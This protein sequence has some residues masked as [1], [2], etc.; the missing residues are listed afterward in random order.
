MSH[1]TYQQEAT[2]AL[3][4]AAINGAAA[5]IFAALTIVCAVLGAAGMAVGCAVFATFTG[6][7][8]WVN[9]TDFILYQKRAD[10]TRPRHT[11][12]L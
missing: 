11:D 4:F 1:H 9:A 5:L 8:A 6:F 3:Q 10:L 7:G 12:H 2:R